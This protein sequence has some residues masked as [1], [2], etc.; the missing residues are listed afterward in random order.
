MRLEKKREVM[1]MCVE[2]NEREG[3]GGRTD[4]TYVE[5]MESERIFVC[6]CIKEWGRNREKGR[7]NKRSVYE[8]EGKKGIE[9]GCV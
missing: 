6:L 7:K 5:G 3:R 4:S 2:S 9:R 1:V 8:K